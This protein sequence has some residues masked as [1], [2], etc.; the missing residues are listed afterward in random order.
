MARHLARPSWRSAP[1]PVSLLLVLAGAA[2]ISAS[3]L[4]AG[5]PPVASAATTASVVPGAGRWIAGHTDF[6]GSYRA[7]VDG[8]WVT[9]Y[10]ISP[11]LRTP[12]RISLATSAR[13]G[14][15]GLTATR[16][17]AQ[18]LTA[19][20]AATN[21][22]AA[23]AVSQ[24]VNFELGN[25]RAVIR[26]ARYLSR[27]VEALASRYVTEA[28][29]DRGPYVLRLQ[30]DSAP[31]PGQSG[32]ATVSLR[33][34][35]GG[36][37]AVVRLR[38]VGPVARPAVVRLDAAGHGSFAFRTVGAGPVRIDAAVGGLPPLTVRASRPAPG[39]QRMITWS[40]A[41]S[42]RAS[43]HYEA[44]VSGFSESYECSSTCNGRPRVSLTACAPG[45]AY[46]STITYAYQ[47]RTHAVPFAAA[48]VRHCATWRVRLLDGARVTASWRYHTPAGWTATLPAGGAFVVDCPAAP[49]VV[50][51]VG[52]DCHVVQLTAVL[53][54]RAG[55][56]AGGLVPMRNDT[57]HDM[58]LDVS[59]AVTRHT[60]LRPGATAVAQTFTLGCGS[61]AAVT[62]RAGVQRTDGQYNYGHVTQMVLN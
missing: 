13:L 21:A 36:H 27:A 3:L 29:R 17:V 57:R 8:H 26:R 58:V 51:V 31:L 35:A 52:V 43:A 56:P 18:T 49:P 23:E 24:A 37:G 48:P 62:V 28:R 10:C 33:G 46:P 41:A 9:V 44:R 1:K 60:V 22:G 38:S 61:A 39:L 7:R 54:H 12:S 11:E 25:R 42:V 47:R 2:T 45:S 20:G 55:G 34:P 50:V 16:E 15:A 19:H 59:G 30:L 5:R 40:P 14:S 32:R 53:G 6:V 4:A